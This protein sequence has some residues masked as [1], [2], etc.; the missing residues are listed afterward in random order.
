MHNV[1]VSWKGMFKSAYLLESTLCCFTGVYPELVVWICHSWREMRVLHVLAWLYVNCQL[2]G[3]VW[4]YNIGATDCTICTRQVIEGCTAVVP[5]TVLLQGWGKQ[6][7]HCGQ[8]SA[9]DGKTS[10][11]KIEIYDFLHS[12]H[13]N[14]LRWINWNSIYNCVFLK[15]VISIG[16]PLLLLVPGVKKLATLLAVLSNYVILKMTPLPYSFIHSFSFRKSVQ[17][18]L[19]HGN[20]SRHIYTGHLTPEHEIS[21]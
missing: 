11:W 13:L 3:C 16:Q 18:Y 5:L 9:S 20:G 8:Q 1:I 21:Q 12:R 4:R 2:W 14:L 17:D 19:I 6:C 10:F 7:S 15:F